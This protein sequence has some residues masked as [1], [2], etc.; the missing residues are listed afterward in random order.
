MNHY[1][2][3]IKR[4]KQSYYVAKAVIDEDDCYEDLCYQAQ[5]AV[6]KALKGLIIFYG[7]EHEH[8][9]V[10]KKLITELKKHTVVDKEVEQANSLTDYAIK[11]KYPDDYDE[12]S[13]AEYDQAIMIAKYCIEWVENKIKEEEKIADFEK[14]LKN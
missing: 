7:V 2:E 14:A 4:A 9:H 8:T 6:E 13:K 5:Q 12:I 3:W 11:T 10:I 1:K